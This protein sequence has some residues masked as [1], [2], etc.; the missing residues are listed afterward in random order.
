MEST[1][2]YHEFME[3]LQQIRS[4]LTQLQARVDAAEYEVRDMELDIHRIY[5]RLENN[6]PIPPWED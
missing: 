4:M 5:R 6:F 2:G 1:D 3:L